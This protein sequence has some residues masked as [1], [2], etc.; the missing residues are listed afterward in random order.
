MAH[1]LDKRT[2]IAIEKEAHLGYDLSNGELMWGLTNREWEKLK[3]MKWEVDITE[4]DWDEYEEISSS[5]S[6][7]Y[8]SVSI[9][10]EMAKLGKCP[11]CGKTFAFRGFKHIPTLRYRYA[12]AVCEPDKF[13]V[14][15]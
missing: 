11:I 9:D 1:R 14:S 10:E 12:F 13:A 3:K 2:I 7:A 8:H 5:K 15:F 4:N 6:Y